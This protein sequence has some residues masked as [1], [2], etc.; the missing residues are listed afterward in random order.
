MFSEAINGNTPETRNVINKLQRKQK[1][2]T[3]AMPQSIK[4]GKKS[5]KCPESVCKKM[6]EH[7]LTIG[8]KLSAKVKSATEQGFKKFLGKRQMSSIALR[9][10]DK[11]EVIVILAGLSNNKS[12]GYIEIRVIVIKGS[13]FVIARYLSNLFNRYIKNGIFP[14]ILKVA[15]VL[16]KGDFKSEPSN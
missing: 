9:P 2:K 5:I 13:K 6:N 3:T 12:P 7:F 8:E 4:I 16:H 10:T 15:K 1:R 11:H 14:D